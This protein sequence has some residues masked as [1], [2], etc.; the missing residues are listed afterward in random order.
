[1]D[2]LDGVEVTDLDNSSRRQLEVPRTVRGALVVNVDPDSNA[3]QAGLR[4]GDVLVE[5]NRQPVR[6]ADDAVKLSE[7]AKGDR[8]LV[9]VWSRMPNGVGGTRYLVVDNAK[10]K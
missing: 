3:A 4:Q 5:I 7:S 10:H 2:A 9:R 6:T 8:I 1:M